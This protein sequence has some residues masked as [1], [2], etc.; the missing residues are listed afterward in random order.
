MAS[1]TST[2][3]T[4]LVPRAIG[5]A[6]CSELEVHLG[7]ADRVLAEFVVNLDRASASAA[8]F[9]AALRDQGVELPDYLVRSLHAVI[10]AIPVINGGAE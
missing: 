4:G 2:A 10:T 5:V 8:S 6:V 1:G 3:G 7:I 9:A